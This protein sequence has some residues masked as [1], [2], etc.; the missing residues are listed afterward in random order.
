M[1][2]FRGGCT[3]A[4]VE[5]VCATTGARDQL[6]ELVADSL[7]R[8]ETDAQGITRFSMLETIREYGQERLGIEARALR[9]R[10]RAHY[11]RAAQQVAAADGAMPEVPGCWQG[12]VSLSRTSDAYTRAL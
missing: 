10:H 12:K 8:A 2:V 4:A 3:A 9:A 6:E 1:S 11:L 5:A 7:L